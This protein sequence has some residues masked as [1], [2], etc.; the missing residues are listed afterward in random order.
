MIESMN[1]VFF[2][3]GDIVTIKHDISNRPTM[4]VKGKETKTIRGNDDA[5]HFKGIRCFWFT[6]DGKYEE[7]TFSTKDLVHVKTKAQ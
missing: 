1:K 7:E 5:T 2:T 6:V 4:L 3:P